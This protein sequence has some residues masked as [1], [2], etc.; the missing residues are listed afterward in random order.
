MLNGLEKE[1]SAA[2]YYLFNGPFGLVILSL[3]YPGTLE[4]SKG[5]IMLEMYPS[6]T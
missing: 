3:E 2:Q 5:I 6:D 1:F 4:E